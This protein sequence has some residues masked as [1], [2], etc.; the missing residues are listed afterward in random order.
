MAVQEKFNKLKDAPH[1][2]KKA[3]AGGI[4]IGVVIVLIFAWGFLFLR[5]VRNA[6]IRSLQNA[7]VPTD[8]FDFNLI[9]NSERDQ[10]VYNPVQ[11]I[12]D[13]RN[14]AA[15]NQGSYQASGAS[16]AG[17]EEDSF[18]SSGGF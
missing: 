18:G 17:F 7:A 15:Q 14:S 4:A 2:D 9:R 1:E 6:D 10:A 13:L 12:R 8:Q 16:S 11:D 3:V 5:N